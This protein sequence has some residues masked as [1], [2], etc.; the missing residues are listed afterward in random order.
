MRQGCAV[1]W[2]ET[3]GARAAVGAGRRRR[4]GKI[5]FLGCDGE[6]WRHRY[7]GRQGRINVLRLPGERRLRVIPM[8]QGRCPVR[9]DVPFCASVV[10]AGLTLL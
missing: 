6:R 9:A 8:R 5:L 2:L 4:A 3:I 1:A 10:A 7:V